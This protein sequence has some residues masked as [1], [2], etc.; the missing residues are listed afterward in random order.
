MVTFSGINEHT[1]LWTVIANELAVYNGQIEHGKSWYHGPE[2]PAAF[3]QIINVAH[4]YE[5]RINGVGTKSLSPHTAVLALISDAR[6]K[7]CSPVMVKAFVDLF[8][9][10]PCGTV[11]ELND[12]TIAVVIKNHND[13]SM[14]TTPAVKPLPG[15]NGRHAEDEILELGDPFLK[16]KIVKTVTRDRLKVN[17]VSELLS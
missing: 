4:R 5:R 13:K 2:Q 10:F 17:I 15:Y 3:S 6:K 12:G 16:L 14:Y 1:L 9:L 11:V 7:R 8:G